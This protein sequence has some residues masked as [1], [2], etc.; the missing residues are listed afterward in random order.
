MQERQSLRFTDKAR[1]LKDV[2][3]IPRAAPG[4]AHGTRCTVVL[5]AE[6]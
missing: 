6:I 3:G 4:G 2:S 1:E 5:V